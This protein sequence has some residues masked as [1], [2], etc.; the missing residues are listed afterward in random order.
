[1]G[2]LVTFLEWVTGREGDLRSQRDDDV[3]LSFHQLLELWLMHLM[4]YLSCTCIAPASVLF[5][6]FFLFQCVAEISG[7]AFPSLSAAAW[8]K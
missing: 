7:V 5:N 8:T 1:M 2:N 4:L 6:F 3:F